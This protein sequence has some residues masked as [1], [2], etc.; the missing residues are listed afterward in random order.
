MQIRYFVALLFSL[1]S[2]LVACSN[3]STSSRVARG[4]P[5]NSELEKKL[6]EVADSVERSLTSLAASQ[7]VNSS[8]VINTAPLITPEGGMGAI[9][10]ID[11]IGPIEPLIYKIATLSSYSVKTFGNAPQ[12]PIIVSITQTKAMI[13]DI[14]K[15]AGLQAGNRLDLVVFPESK[16]IEM[17]YKNTN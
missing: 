2:L 4:K 5:D 16:I 3:F 10:D 11:W 7:E 15:N 6:V 9:V 17:R 13:A 14:L 12:I 1:L 8:N